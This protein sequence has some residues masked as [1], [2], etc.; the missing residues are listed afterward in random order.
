MS[1]HAKD[2]NCINGVGTF[3]GLYNKARTMVQALVWK[4]VSTVEGY[5][6]KETRCLLL[7]LLQHQGKQVLSLLCSCTLTCT[8]SERPSCSSTPW[9]APTEQLAAQWASIHLPECTACA[10]SAEEGREHLLCRS[11]P[12]ELRGE[13]QT[14]WI[15][16]IRLYLGGKKPNT[17][18]TQPHKQ[19]HLILS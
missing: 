1:L 3:I 5:R 18:K 15:Q 14:K 7:H 19:K 17:H 2:S 4:Q 6:F 11:T 9:A 12:Q 16:W 10:W 8:S 13:L